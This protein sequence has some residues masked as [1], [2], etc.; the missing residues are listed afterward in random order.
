MSIPSVIVLSK[1][2]KVTV[3]LGS[4]KI[5]AV[6]FTSFL[7]QEIHGRLCDAPE[8]EKISNSFSFFFFVFWKTLAPSANVFRASKGD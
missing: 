1:S 5:R 3:R 4:K 7:L 6:N 2:Q 8:Q